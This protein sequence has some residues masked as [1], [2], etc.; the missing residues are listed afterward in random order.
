MSRDYESLYKAVPIFRS[1][2]PSEMD[3]IVAI[4]RLFRA[5]AGTVVLMEGQQ[6]K[7]MYV[8]VQGRASARMRLFQ[9]DD[10]H[11]GTLEKGDVFGELSLIDN[12]PVSATVTAVTDSILYFVDR[13][14]LSELRKALRPAAF[15]L[16]R[17]LAP[18]ICERLRQLN[19]RIEDMFSQPEIHLRLM[20]DRY[21]HLAQDGALEAPPTTIPPRSDVL[22]LPVR[23]GDD[24]NFV[25]S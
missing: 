14:Q 25:K 17:A 10:A 4:S 11:L 13:A 7:G 15:K 2:S 23:P 19:A 22:E 16:L 18:T 12:Q 21:R 6:G 9:G 20:E 24:P 5:P 3:E 8:V 1:L